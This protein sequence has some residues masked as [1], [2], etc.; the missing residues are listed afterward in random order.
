MSCNLLCLC[1]HYWKGESLHHP[2]RSSKGN[3]KDM[4]TI[5]FYNI[6]HLSPKYLFSACFD[7]LV[8]TKDSQDG[9]GD[10]REAM[11]VLPYMVLDG[12]GEGGTF[13]WTC[14]QKAVLLWFYDLE[15]KVITLIFKCDLNLITILVQIK[16]HIRKWSHSRVIVLIDAFENINSSVITPGPIFPYYSNLIFV[17]QYHV[18]AHLDMT[19][20]Y[21]RI[22]YLVGSDQVLDSWAFEDFNT[23]IS[24]VP[25]WMWEKRTNIVAPWDRLLTIMSKLLIYRWVPL[26]PDFLGAWKSVR[27][28]HYPAYPIIIISLIIQKN[29]ATKIWA[30]QESGLT[31]VWL[32][33]D[34]P[35]H[36]QRFTSVK[37]GSFLNEHLRRY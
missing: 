8:Y 30:K 21:T 3:Y 28:K 6:L 20:L 12:A 31:A 26:K 14:S 27:L 5:C 29:L 13:R 34:P 15:V 32:K 23:N 11:N 36:I 25:A 19:L 18:M 17:F 10:L 9:H 16:N 7:P 37:L 4:T 22:P 33:R 24:R 2:S 35:V 1:I